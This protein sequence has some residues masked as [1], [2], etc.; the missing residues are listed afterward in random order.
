MEP[1]P[2]EPMP[3]LASLAMLRSK[4]EQRNPIFECKLVRHIRD[5]WVLLHKNDVTLVCNL[6]D[7]GADFFE[8]C[9]LAMATEPKERRITPP[10]NVGALLKNSSLSDFLERRSDMLREY[11]GI[12]IASGDLVALPD[13]AFGLAPPLHVLSKFLQELCV[14]VNWTDETECFA[15]IC[16]ALGRL[17][18]NVLWTLE[19]IHVLLPNMCCAP[20]LALEPLCTISKADV[21]S[22]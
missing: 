21:L 18:S 10:I 8:A 1:Q 7:G 4:R 12:N 16:V 3:E 6:A 2:S 13:L 19:T 9:A 5:G 15:G 22:I 17:F 14:E 20:S 11:F